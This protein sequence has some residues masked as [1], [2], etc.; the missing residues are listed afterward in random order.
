MKDRLVPKLNAPWPTSTE[1]FL[2][3]NF[4][5]IFWLSAS[6]LCSGI[7]STSL[8]FIFISEL[9]DNNLSTYSKTKSLLI[10]F[11]SEAFEVKKYY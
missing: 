6:H 3:A 10:L 9:E 11:I 4:N 5:N 7:D 8:A 1:T 2:F